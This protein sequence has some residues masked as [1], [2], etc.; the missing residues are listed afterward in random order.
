MTFQLINLQPLHAAYQL[1]HKRRR[2]LILVVY[3]PTSK[4]TTTVIHS[5]LYVQITHH[6]RRA[7]L[8]GL[9]NRKLLTLC[10]RYSPTTTDRPTALI[11]TI[12]PNKVPTIN[13]RAIYHAHPLPALVC[14]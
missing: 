4:L 12:K 13:A 10:S 1:P 2:K 9:E 8:L 3:I 5:S 11:H 14:D 6:P 7:G